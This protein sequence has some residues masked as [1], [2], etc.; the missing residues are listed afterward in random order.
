M[1]NSAHCKKLQSGYTGEITAHFSVPTRRRN[2]SPEDKS[3]LVSVCNRFY[4]PYGTD[5]KIVLQ[6][7]VLDWR[8]EC[9]IQNTVPVKSLAAFWQF[10]QSEEPKIFTWLSHWWVPV[11]SKIRRFALFNW[12]R[13]K[14]CCDC[15]KEP[16]KKR[17]HQKT[18]STTTVS[19]PT[20]HCTTK[21]ELTAFYKIIHKV[22]IQ[23]RVFPYILT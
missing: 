1:C 9:D 21:G 20:D 3:I 19:I 18:R 12:K 7:V 8:Q 5:I 17:S 11:Q 10:L 4:W 16:T 23:W 2:G 13:T 15:Y 6:W 22:E 14:I